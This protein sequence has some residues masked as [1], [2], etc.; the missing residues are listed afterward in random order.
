MAVCERMCVCVCV[1]GGG[2]GGGGG[3]FQGWRGFQGK[4]S[5]TLTIVCFRGDDSRA[6]WDTEEQEVRTCLVDVRDITHLHLKYCLLFCM[7]TV[8]VCVCRGGEGRDV[9]ENCRLPSLQQNLTSNFQY[10]TSNQWSPN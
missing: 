7:H 1:C 10:F 2:G 6:L 3:G 9:C 4:P 8:C 5:I